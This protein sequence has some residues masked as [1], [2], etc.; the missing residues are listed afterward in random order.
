MG[1]QAFDKVAKTFKNDYKDLTGR[2][3]EIVTGTKKTLQD[4]DIFLEKVGKDEMLGEEGYYLNIGGEQ[5]KEKYVEI[6]ASADSGCLYG[7]ISI[8]Q[9]LK[10][11]ADGRS[12]LPKGLIK[13]YPK[14]EQR[15]MHLDV[16]RKWIPMEYLKDLSKQMSWYKLNLLALHLSDND[17]WDGLSTENG[18]NG[19]ARGWFRLESETFPNLASEQCY[20][21]KEFRDFQYDSMELGINVVPELDTPG[22]ALAYTEAWGSES[23]REDNTKYLDV[24]NPQVLENAKALFDEY[25]NGYQG[26]EPTFVG[27]YVNIGTN[28]YKTW[29]LSGE[30]QT[31]YRE[32]F[33]KYCNDLLEYVNSTGKEAVFWGSLTENNGNTPVTTDAVMFA[34]YQGYANAKQSL[35]AGCRVIS[36]EDQDV[37]IVPGGGAYSNQ[38]GRAEHIYN[39]WLLNRNSGWAGNPAPD[40]H[41]RVLGGQLAVWNDFH[42]NGISV[43]DI[44]YRIQHNLYAV[45]EKTWAGPQAKQSGKSYA[46]VKKLAEQLGDAPN[47]DFMYEVDKEVI[48]HE[49]LKLNGKV[50]NNAQAGATVKEY[51]NVT[52]RVPGK[53]GTALQFNGK[54]SYLSTDIKSPGFDWTTAMWINPETDGNGSL[55]EGK[56]GT[57][58]LEDGKLKYQI[59]GYTHTFDCAIPSGKW[60]HITLTGTF[61]GVALYIN[62]QKLDALIGKPFPYWNA[63]SGC[64]SWDGAGYPVNEKGEQTQRYYESDC[65]KLSQC[66]YRRRSFRQQGGGRRFGKQMGI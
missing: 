40:G 20:T 54:E 65:R 27:D 42:G 38:F 41:P 36:M 44:S 51:K 32:G 43:N 4:G 21:K 60:T 59:E 52:E 56:T 29:G 35:D 39:N 61:E 2:E 14:F 50:K 19:A 58:R 13:D 11:D 34:W 55:M 30:K 9:M 3:I 64:N 53:K 49:L 10:Q 31:Q 48:D 7:T 66:K 57:L 47:A 37:Y 33:R 28:E 23:A 8:L 63:Q 12:H 6:K 46:D 16:A 25:I 62:G 15:G 24:L 18:K 5:A 1:D 22:H 17:I 26:G 45:A